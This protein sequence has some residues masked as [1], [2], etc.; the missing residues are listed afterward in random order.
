M[1]TNDKLL[2]LDKI[3]CADICNS[4]G[5]PWGESQKDITG[6]LWVN[7]SCILYPPN[8]FPQEA[9]E[10]SYNIMSTKQLVSDECFLMPFI[11]NKN[12][13]Y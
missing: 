13:K 1:S 3:F 2:Y 9:F 8:I 12:I 6:T 5:E 11:I 7:D 10:Y 4:K